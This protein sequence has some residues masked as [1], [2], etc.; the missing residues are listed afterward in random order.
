MDADGEGVYQFVQLE[1]I[2]AHGLAIH[3]NRQVL[4]LQVEGGNFA[5]VA[6]VHVLVVVVADLHDAIADAEGAIADL[7]LRLCLMPAD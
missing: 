1:E 3:H 2:V 7:P 6:V 4:H 5:D